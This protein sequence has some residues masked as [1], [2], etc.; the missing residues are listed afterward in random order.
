MDNVPF[1]D[2]H[3]RIAPVRQELL[4]AYARVID[5][6][7]FVMGRETE[8]LEAE[9]AAFCGVRHAV[10]VNS[11]TAALQLALLALGIGPGD[12]VITV[13]HTFIATVEAITAAGASPVLVD[14]DP[15]TYLIDIDAVEAA[16]SPRTRAIIPVH[17][18]GLPCDMDRL[19]SIARGHG[20]ALIEDAC[21]AHGARFGGRRVGSFGDAGCFSFYPAKNLGTTGEGGILVTDDAALAA[22]ARRLRS[23]GESARYVHDEPGWNLRLSEVLAAAVRVQLPRLDEWNERRRAAARLYAG[24]LLGLPLRLPA[25][26]RDR[27]H[28]YHL[29]VVETADRDGVRASL[30]S[31]GI[32]TAVHYPAPVHMQRAYAHLGLAGALPVTEAAAANILSLPM[33]PEITA[34]Q[35]DAV[36]SA[37]DAAIAAP[38]GRA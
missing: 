27:E 1:V 17:L 19:S 6:G 18:Y 34:A 14:I 15:E 26:P 12:E 4:A 3:A 37:L 21:Q 35:V 13:S 32:A 8:A 16:I 5:S 31:R 23:H 33:Y 36:A 30:Q 22:R 25:E 24:A 28:V 7:V 9:F 11:G 38:I 20:V 10:A 29:Y 2:M